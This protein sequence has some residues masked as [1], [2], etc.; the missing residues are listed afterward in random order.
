MYYGSYIFFGTASL[1]HRRVQAHVAR[2]AARL[3]CERTKMLIIDMSEVY[4]MDATAG[5]IF[6]KVLRLA[7]SKRIVLV[8]AGLAPT[9][10]DELRRSGVL[11]KASPSFS[12]LDRAEKC[13]PPPRHR[14]P[15][16]K[17][18]GR[19][20]PWHKNTATSSTYWNN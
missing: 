12:T 17:A 9:V 10:A 6:Q 2:D 8:W 16:N 11:G 4:G 1:L 5:A 14:P 7:K 13:T 18:T 15:P 20:G 19:S 3:R